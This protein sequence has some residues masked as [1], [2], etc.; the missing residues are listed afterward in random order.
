MITEYFWPQLDD[1]YLGDMWF[2]PDGTTQRMSQ[3]MY[4]KPSLENMASHEM[5]VR[6]DAVRLFPVGLR[7]VY[8]PCQQA[9][10]D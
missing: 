6:F 10:D 3:S 4:W 1:M 8:G 9:S 7:Q 5:V 2:Q